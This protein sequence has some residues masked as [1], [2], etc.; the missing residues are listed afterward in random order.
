MLISSRVPLLYILFLV[1]II[2]VHILNVKD[3]WAKLKDIF[4]VSSS[5]VGLKFYEFN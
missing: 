4:S 1:D 3:G 5:L 2:L